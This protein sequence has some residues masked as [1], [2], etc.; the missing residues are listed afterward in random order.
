MLKKL[1]LS[2]GFSIALFSL[3]SLPAFAEND[4]SCNGKVLGRSAQVNTDA[5]AFYF[6]SH[7][8]AKDALL[9]TGANTVAPLDVAGITG[10]GLA[11]KDRKY[12]ACIAD[13]DNNPL[14][15]T[16]YLLKG[17]A[18]NDNLGFISFACKSG[19]NEG[20]NC[21]SY[22]YGVKIGA[23]DAQGKRSLSGYAWNETFGYINFS[24][25]ATGKDGN[26]QACGAIQ[27]GIKLAADGSFSGN[28]WTQAGVWIDLNGVKGQIPG[29]KIEPPIEPEDWCDGR[30]YLCLEVTPNPEELVVP[31]VNGKLPG[32][33][34]ISV[35]AEDQ[36]KVA[37]GVDGYD[38]YLYL[39]DADGV[40]PLDMNV[41][42][43]ATT[44]NWND[45]LMADQTVASSTTSAVL[46]KPLSLADFAVQAAGVYK[47][48]KKI[49]SVA[50]TTNEN[51]SFTTS[52]KPAAPVR[53]QTFLV[54]VGLPK[55]PEQALKLKSITYKIT[56]K[57][58]GSL[59]KEDT[60][61]PNGIIDFDFKF[62]PWVDLDTLYVNNYQDNIVAYREIPV[63]F[64][65]SARAVGAVTPPSAM[66]ITL[67][68]AYSAAKT[69]ESQPDCKED[70]DKFNFYFDP[71]SANQPTSKTY[72]LSTLANGLDVSAVA[73]LPPKEEGEQVNICN[74]AEGPALYSVVTYSTN[75][76]TVK[77][78][79]NKLPRVS[80]GQI[81]NT[82]AVIHGNVYAQKSFSPSAQVGAIQTS[83]NVNVN[84]IRDT[85]NE[86]VRK[87]L[88]GKSPAKST[89]GCS[90]TTWGSNSCGSSYSSS[91]SVKT[92]SVMYFKDTDVTLNLSGGWTGSKVLI[93]DGGNV[94]IEK[95]LYSGDEDYTDK[96]AILAFK[97]YSGT[98]ASGGNVYIGPDVKN[99]QANFVVD[100]TIFSYKGGGKT[101][102]DSTTGEPK[103]AS[104]EEMVATLKNQ[105]LVQGSISS[106]NTIGGADSDQAGFLYDGTG[107]TYKLPVTP[108][109]R[110]KVQLYDVN[111]WRLV[112]LE[113]RLSDEGLPLD[114]SCKKA[115]SVDEI[116]QIQKWMI[117]EADPVLGEDDVE[118]DGINPLV[119]Y[120]SN[121]PDGDLMPPADSAVLSK[122]LDNNKEYDPVYVYYVAPSETSFVFSKPGSLTEK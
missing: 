58:D 117:G 110:R 48:K 5:G 25:D 31:D 37:N 113:L 121:S 50:P 93:V 105:L 70:L 68:L 122:V 67:K 41:Y 42:N 11:P 81:S 84:I 51:L 57:A 64:K 72:T 120:S 40:T 66:N 114:Q 28:A 74:V 43:V 103:W 30:P 107:K 95:D 63:S 46:N 34:T 56:K 21:G 89:S 77:Y 111:Y 69:L 27:Y 88:A 118:C 22:D 71:G 18:W 73:S 4:V 59:V 24:C 119:Q 32:S 91:F 52:T 23:K 115:L 94:Y 35:D 10:T 15:L 104:F 36:V 85:I 44:F 90:V 9:P 98:Y 17:Y 78:F 1:I 14:T 76:K 47:T 65:V 60:V 101:N 38:M 49:A 109:Q 97:N 19:K 54:D 7:D 55:V 33:P 108:D 82:A 80:E 53:N 8:G 61:Y 100:G 106:R 26:G 2:S 13:A 79:S 96:M 83:G 20:V 112:K 102:V 92:E 29:E 12:A 16:N 39:R 75:G 87:Y 62:R 86:N 3:L 99:I 116:L 6:D 45:T